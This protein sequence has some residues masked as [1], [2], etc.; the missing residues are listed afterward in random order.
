MQ[1]SNGGNQHSAGTYKLIDFVDGVY[2][3]LFMRSIIAEI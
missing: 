2:R 1:S 3:T